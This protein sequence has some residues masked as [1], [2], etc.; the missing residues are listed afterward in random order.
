MNN[1][2]KHIYLIIA[3]SQ[4]KLLQRLIL[5]LVILLS[6]LRQNILVYLAKT[7]RCVLGWCESD[8]S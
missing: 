4:L 5:A 7:I 8:Q 3:H 2:N 6:D 1:K